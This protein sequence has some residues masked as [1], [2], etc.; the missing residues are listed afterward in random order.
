MTVT[1]HMPTSF[2]DMLTPSPHH[3]SCI[4]QFLASFDPSSIAQFFQCAV[5]PASTQAHTI[6]VNLHPSSRLMRTMR[7]L[8]AI[9]KAFLPGLRCLANVNSHCPLIVDT[10]ASVCITPFA[11]DFV[12]YR[13]SNAKI[14]DLSKYNAVAGEGEV[15][16]DVFDSN[17]L[18]ITLVLPAFHIPTVEVR[19][20]SPQVLLSLR[21]GKVI[22]TAKHISIKLE[23]GCKFIA[24]YNQHSNLPELQV[25][26]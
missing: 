23:D 18:P 12:S 4:E 22:Q 17:G 10:G 9:T 8:P 15:K 13:K 2:A 3:L 6:S 25:A 7:C 26:S 24:N 11:T 5:R 21:G 16:W 1:A 20:L 19:L 14:R